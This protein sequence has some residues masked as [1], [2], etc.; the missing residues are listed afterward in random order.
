MLGLGEKEITVAG[1]HF[2]GFAEPI[3]GML[4]PPQLVED[5]GMADRG[6]D[7]LRVELAGFAEVVIG[8]FKN[9]PTF[10]IG[11]STG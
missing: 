2:E 3:A 1:R 9:L 10:R 4:P 5:G 7:I 8:L 11:Q 6:K